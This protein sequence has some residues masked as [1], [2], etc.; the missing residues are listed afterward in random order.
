MQLNLKTNFIYIGAILLV[1][2]LALLIINPISLMQ[3]DQRQLR[4]LPND[5]ELV[6]LGKDV[7]AQQC[8]AC[9]GANLE[10]QANWRQR[11]NKGYMPAPPHDAN[12]HTWH[13]PDEYLFSVTKYGIEET[14]GREY[15]N[16]MPAYETHLTDKQIVAV[17]SYI[18]STWSERIQ[19]Q[20]DQ[21]NIRANNQ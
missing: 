10:G 7:Y 14:L 18:K 20:H 4:L 5:K 1:I 17:L 9:H 2:G 12:G 8:A 11:D 6:L 3:D 13:H 21:I 19:N 15:P 16:N